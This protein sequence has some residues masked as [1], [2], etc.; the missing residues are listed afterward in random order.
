MRRF[1]ARFGPCRLGA[2]GLG[3]EGNLGADCLVQRRGLIAHAPH[4]GM[5]RRRSD[6]LGAHG[7]ARQD[8]RVPWRCSFR[9]HIATESSSDT[10]H[11]FCLASR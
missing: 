7:P 3:H 6:A 8:S 10:S 9:V 5:A 11:Q 4:E 1:W 2:L